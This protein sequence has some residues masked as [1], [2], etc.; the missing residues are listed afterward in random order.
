MRSLRRGAS[1]RASDEDE[2]DEEDAELEEEDGDAGSGERQHEESED[3]KEDGKGAKAAPM[4][5]LATRVRTGKLYF[6]FLLKDHLP[7]PKVWSAFFKG[8]SGT[9]VGLFAHCQDTVACERSGD[10][11]ALGIQLVSTVPSKWCVDLVSPTWQLL[12]EALRADAAAPGRG[13]RKYIFV[14]DSTLPLRPLQGFRQVLFKSD[15]SDICMSPENEWASVDIFGTTYKIVKSHQWAVL[16]QMD[17]EAF[18]RGWEQ[19]NSYS[20]FVKNGKYTIG[21][22][23]YHWVV[24]QM[25]SNGRANFSATIHRKLIPAP[26]RCPDE[27]VLTTLIFG[28]HEPRQARRWKTMMESSACR[29]YVNWACVNP[30]EVFTRVTDK[31]LQ[32]SQDPADSAYLFAR[33]FDKKANLED[34]KALLQGHRF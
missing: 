12:R 6:L 24:P 1:R 4:E 18:V 32:L 17:A 29:T 8:S 9:G 13:P 19:A 23:E 14:S 10:F 30:P 33:K 5:D 21:P 11:G 31:L 20:S 7:H 34:L 26:G 16:N 2:E 15:H 25:G 27:E 22:S 3:A 28:L